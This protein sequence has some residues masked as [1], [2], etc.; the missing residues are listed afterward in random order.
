VSAAK[1]P[2]GGGGPRHSI[3]TVRLF[4]TGVSQSTRNRRRFT[5]LGGEGGKSWS[6]RLTRGTGD[7]R[8]Y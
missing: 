1:A 4:A 7:A 3:L 8:N 5:I 2:V 6:V